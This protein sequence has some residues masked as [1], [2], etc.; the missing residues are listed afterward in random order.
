MLSFTSGNKDIAVIKGGPFKGKVLKINLE[1]KEDPDIENDYPEDVLPEDFYRMNLDHRYNRDAKFNIIEPIRQAI[2]SGS[3]KLI[4]KSALPLYRKALNEIKQSSKKEL[5]LDDG[6]L[7]PLPLLT[8]QDKEIEHIYIAGPTGSGKSTWVG[9]YIELYKKIYKKRPVWVFSRLDADEAL[10]KYKVKRIGLDEG[11][12]EDPMSAE[13]FTKGSDG[14]LVIFDDIDTIPNKDINKEVH[15][16]RDDL[17]ETGRHENVSVI[18]TGHQLMDYKKTRNLLN[19]A[20]AVTVFPKSG[21]GYHI[22]RFLKVYC[23][24]DKKNIQKI[25]NLPSRWVTI[26]KSYPIYVLHEKGAILI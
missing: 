9:K 20:T 1:E 5:I 24:M 7:I 17:L 16:L 4:P 6:T 8:K 10:D 11:L 2:K 21:S 18:S 23:G 26:Y 14:A 13:D 22:A 15:R 25:M 3:K 19:E 12:L